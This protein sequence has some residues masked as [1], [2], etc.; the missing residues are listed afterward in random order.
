MP[1]KFDVNTPRG[2]ETIN[3]TSPNGVVEL[4]NP[5][6]GFSGAPRDL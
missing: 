5:V 3:H 2:Q 6:C 4:A 1:A